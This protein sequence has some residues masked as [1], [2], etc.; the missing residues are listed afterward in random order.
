MKYIQ[1]H[2]RDEEAFMLFLIKNNSFKTLPKK[3]YIKN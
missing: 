2:I 1:N 3:I